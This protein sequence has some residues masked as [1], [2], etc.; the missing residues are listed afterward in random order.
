MPWTEE[1]NEKLKKLFK[2]G[3]N[4]NQISATLQRTIGGIKSHLE[5]LG[6]INDKKKK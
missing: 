1:Q 5:K 2:E 4:I 3:Y 6:F